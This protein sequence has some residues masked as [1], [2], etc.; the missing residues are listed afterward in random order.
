[1]PGYPDLPKALLDLGDERRRIA[2]LLRETATLRY[3]MAKEHLDPVAPDNFR[4]WLTEKRAALQARGNDAQ[5]ISKTL[6]LLPRETALQAEVQNF[7]R[8]IRKAA[9]SE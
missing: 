2:E 1:M 6:D 3:A 8:E 5:W 9:A 4:R 7:T